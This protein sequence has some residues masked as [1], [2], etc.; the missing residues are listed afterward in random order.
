[1]RKFFFFSV[2]LVAASALLVIFSDDGAS[3]ARR[4]RPPTIRGKESIVFPAATE[5]GKEYLGVSFSHSSHARFGF[6]K[7]TACHNDEVFTKD[8]A[9]GVN[10]IKMDE[11][12][13]GKWCGHCH[14]GKLLT[15]E[16]KPVFPP[17]LDGVDQC[18][19]CHNVKPWQKPEEGKGWKP[20]ATVKPAEGKIGDEGEGDDDEE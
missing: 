12:Y 4:K 14:N 19:L 6:K 13:E 5:D 9:L 8:Q 10:A 1:M 7:C 16:E 3:S 15:K 17:R 18:V 20:P 2:G 11:I